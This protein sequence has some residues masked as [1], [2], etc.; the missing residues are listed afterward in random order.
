MHRPAAL[1]V[2]L[3]AP[4]A[5][6]AEPPPALIEATEAASAACQARGGTPRI[7]PHY[8]T[9]RDLNGDGRPDFVTDLAGLECTGAWD[10]LCTASGCPVTAWL[11]APGGGHDRFDL[12]PLRG[13]DIS[14]AEA[15][16]LPALVSHHDAAD[17]GPDAVEGC[18][19]TWRFTTNYPDRPEPDAPATPVVTPAAATAPVKAAPELSGWSLRRVQG[20]SPVALGAG[21]GDLSS[22]A[23]FCLEDQPFLALTFHDRPQSESVTLDFAFS[24]GT[25]T[26]T[27]GYESTAG[28]A[29]VVALKGSPLA[30]RLAGRDS[31]VE[32]RVDGTAEGRLSL[33]GSTKALRGALADCHA[34]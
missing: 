32:V 31:E 7:L 30:S 11:S 17:C 6:A 26:V 22:L 34:F 27:A 29:Y 12:G 10:A 23:A 16:A 21:P 14:D 9:S 5:A 20:A 15:G 13:F 28:G 25:L 19:R 33:S 1:A 24:Q 8:E 4:L 3:L 18:T 2:L